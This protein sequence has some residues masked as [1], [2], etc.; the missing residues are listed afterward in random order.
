M[1]LDLDVE[2]L[3]TTDLPGVLG[4]LA[5]LEAR[6]RLRL[7][8]PALTTTLPSRLLDAAEAAAI[9]GCSERWLRAATRALSCRRDLSRKQPRW[10]ENGLRRWLAERRRP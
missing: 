7:A 1:S 4:R 2:A 10:D 5:E 3:E 8:R 9:A 6:V